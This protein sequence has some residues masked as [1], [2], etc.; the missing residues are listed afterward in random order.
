MLGMVCCAQTIAVK[1]HDPRIRYT[2]RIVMADETAEL[3]W[4]CTFLKINFKG[5]GVKVILRDEHGSNYFNVI[6]DDN[7]IAVIHPDSVQKEY[8]LVS[9][10]PDENHSL[11]LF[12]RT[13]WSR[14]KTWF[15]QFSLDKNSNILPAPPVKKRKMEFFGNS[16]SCGVAVEDSSGKDNAT[17]RY[18]NAYLSYAAI[19]ARHFDA[20]FHNTSHGGIG[21]M[22]SWF[23][24]VT[25]EMYNLLDPTDFQS[26]WDFKKFT[27]DVVVINIGQNDSWIVKLPENE[28]FKARFGKTAPTDDQIIRAYRKFVKTIRDTYPKAQIICTLGSMDAAKQGS[29]WPGYIEKAVTQLGDK[30]IYCHVFLYKNT[31]G[32]PNVKEQQAMADDLIGFIEQHIKW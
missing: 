13:E 7:V 27:P 20:E 18:E 24:L 4:P 22:V 28:Q 30:N 9:G 6:V 5:T 12:K 19:T 25:P 32:H 29:P 8:T 21:L 1:V 26:L 17:S 10:L 11:E 14:G 3:S 2:G 16:I 15:Y 31:P 23:P